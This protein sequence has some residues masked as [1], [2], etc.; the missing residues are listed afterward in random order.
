MIE[1]A[2][3]FKGHEMTFAERPGGGYQVDIVRVGGG[4][5][6]GHTAIHASLQEAIDEAKAIIERQSAAGC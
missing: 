4:G 2:L 1:N 6:L 5:Q 3:Q